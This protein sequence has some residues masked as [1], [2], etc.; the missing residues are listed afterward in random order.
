MRTIQLIDNIDYPEPEIDKL[1]KHHAILCEIA[2]RLTELSVCI[3]S[4]QVAR[5]LRQLDKIHHHSPRAFRLILDV[6]SSQRSLEDSLA[7]LAAR[8]TNSKG[9][10]T[11]RQNW[12]QNMQTDVET[13]KLYLPEWGASLETIMRRRR[14][15]E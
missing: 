15:T 9:E 3:G 14:E 4:P 7:A 10:P 12:L 11:T 5:I 13:I 2:E 1:P 8:H 6:L